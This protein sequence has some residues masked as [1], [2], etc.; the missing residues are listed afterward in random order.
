MPAAKTAAMWRW[1]EMDLK[2][3]V[4]MPPIHISSGACHGATHAEEIDVA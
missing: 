2:V 1:D 4:S 3:E